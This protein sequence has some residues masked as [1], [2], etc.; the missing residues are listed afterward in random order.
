[1]AEFHLRRMAFYIALRTAPVTS[2]A[3]STARRRQE[4]MQTRQ[5]SLRLRTPAGSYT[6]R[7]RRTHGLTHGIADRDVGEM[8]ARAICSR[9]SC[10][11]C[12]SDVSG[13]VV[14]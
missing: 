11:Q 13:S 12:G 7:A 5:Q 14:L 10:Q 6:P 1:M 2:G 4:A 3:G 8:R 9:A